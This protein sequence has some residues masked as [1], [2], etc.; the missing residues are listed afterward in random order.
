MAGWGG[1]L[2]RAGGGGL[3]CWASW[4]VEV[5]RS[6]EAKLE[7]SGGGA[8]A[9]RRQAAWAEERARWAGGRCAG[10][11]RWLGA[12]MEAWAG[13]G[14]I[15]GGVGAVDRADIDLWQRMDRL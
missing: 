12:A 11:V 3:A 15:G 6:E 14:R 2:A 8:E 9:R 5:G 13:A 7:A 10:R 1:G 4:A